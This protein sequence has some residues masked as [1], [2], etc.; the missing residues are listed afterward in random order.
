MLRFL[1][2]C[3]YVVR[4]LYWFVDLLYL[5]VACFVCRLPV[6]LP[7]SLWTSCHCIGFWF[8]VD[9]GFGGSFVVLI[10]I[11][12]SFVLSAVYLCCLGL[13]RWYLVC[14]LF[15]LA[16]LILLLGAFVVVWLD[17]FALVLL[18]AVGWQILWGWLLLFSYF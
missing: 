18:D 1:L 11:F 15:G 4:L 2:I 14:G 12:V 6:S 16:V 10:L 13:L 17:L 8:V 5:R 9:F 7:S 3:V